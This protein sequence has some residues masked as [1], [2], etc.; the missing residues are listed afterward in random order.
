[1]LLSDQHAV[2][3]E[4]GIRCLL[5][6][7]APW[8]LCAHSIVLFA[9]AIHVASA[10]PAATSDSLIPQLRKQGTATQ[11]VVDGKPYLILGGEVGNSAGTPREAMAP[12]WPRLVALNLN[13]V[14][15]PAYW[16]LVEPTEGEFDFALVD[17]LIEDARRHNLRLGLLWFG[18]WKEST[19]G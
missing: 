9:I 18:R 10:Q 5:P 6:L 13:T 15:V 14:L 19:A 12:V 7:F 11:L 4:E 17:G 8:R 2:G 16:D 3:R 1:M